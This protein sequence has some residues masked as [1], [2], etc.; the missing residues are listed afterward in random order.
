M[1][2]IKQL[3]IFDYMLLTDEERILLK[4]CSHYCNG[5]KEPLPW[6]SE[7]HKECLNNQL[8]VAKIK[9]YEAKKITYDS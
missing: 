3:D 8:N 7:E 4:N 1:T 5:I 9:K 2:Q 6:E